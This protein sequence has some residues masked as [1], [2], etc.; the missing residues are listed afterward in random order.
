[1]TGNLVLLVC[2]ISICL[3]LAPGTGFPARRRRLRRNFARVVAVAAVLPRPVG[4]IPVLSLS[5]RR[6]GPGQK[7]YKAYEC[8]DAILHM[9]VIESEFRGALKDRRAPFRPA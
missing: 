2:F 8:D 4:G 6:C 3:V 5:E 9:F 1:M 7:G